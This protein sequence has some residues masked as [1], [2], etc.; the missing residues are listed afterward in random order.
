[1]GI[2]DVF[3]IKDA[4]DATSVDAGIEGW[5]AIIQINNVITRRYA[6][7]TP[8]SL[9]SRSINFTGVGADAGTGGIQFDTGGSFTLLD[10]GSLG[11]TTNARN[12]LFIPTMIGLMVH[13]QTTGAMSNTFA[14]CIGVKP[15]TVPATPVALTAAFSLTCST[16]T[17]S[18]ANVG[19]YAAMT[20]VSGTNTNIVPVPTTT[21]PT[22][23]IA[24]NFKGYYYLCPV[25]KGWWQHPV[26]NACGGIPMRGFTIQNGSVSPFIPDGD[27]T[28]PDVVYASS[29][30]YSSIVLLATAGTNTAR[31]AIIDLYGIVIPSAVA[32]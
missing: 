25:N 21:L 2:D 32:V 18:G 8:L 20:N 7:S 23:G 16:A 19:S 24:S 5:D 11:S 15:S 12:L 4:E 6:A 29:N 14:G 17:L 10:V 30:S 27:T 1:M 3:S 31:F 22:A 13:P 9:I 26:G 28:D